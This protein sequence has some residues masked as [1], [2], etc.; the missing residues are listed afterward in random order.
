VGEDW[1]KTLIECISNLGCN[2]DRKTRRQALKYCVIDGCLYWWTV[3]G[4][5][6]KCLNKEETKVAMGEVHE[7]MCGA[8]QS[9][10]KMCWMLK[11]PGVYWPEM[12]KDC[13][14]YYQGC[15]AC[16]RFGKLQIA[17]SSVLHPIIKP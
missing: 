1:R 15:E 5:L 17:S 16:Q 2:H 4:I 13:L 3:D 7:G 11:R 6:V 12:V 10:Q 8:H 14:E 9:G